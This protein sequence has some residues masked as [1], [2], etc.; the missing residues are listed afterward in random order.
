MSE[1]GQRRAW[2]VTNHCRVTEETID[3]DALTIAAT[4]AVFVVP[5]RSKIHA[6]A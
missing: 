3:V 5:P 1:R 4:A 6:P 2:L